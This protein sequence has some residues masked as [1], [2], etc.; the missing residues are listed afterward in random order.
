MERYSTNAALPVGT[1]CGL[2]VGVLVYADT[3]AISAAILFGVIGAVVVAALWLRRVRAEQQGRN[4]GVPTFAVVQ[5]AL[6]VVL[7]VG[8]AIWTG[9]WFVGVVIAAVAVFWAFMVW[10]NRGGD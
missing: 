5:T 6:L 3:H 10:R 2:I 1:L 9:S 7:G 4:L 8:V